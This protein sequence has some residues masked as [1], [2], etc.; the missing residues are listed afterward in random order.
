MT[1]MMYIYASGMVSLE[2]IAIP[3]IPHLMKFEN[4]SKAVSYVLIGSNL[5]LLVTYIFTVVYLR[6]ALKQPKE[7]GSFEKQ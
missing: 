2:I 7:F 6:R 1:T 5:S 4:R 3:L